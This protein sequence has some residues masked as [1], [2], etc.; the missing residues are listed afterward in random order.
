ME[1]HTPPEM[2]HIFGIWIGIPDDFGKLKKSSVKE[3]KGQIMDIKTKLY[4]AERI[5][6]LSRECQL[7]AF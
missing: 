2:L 1:E 7:S 4:L 6:Y 5:W 3:M